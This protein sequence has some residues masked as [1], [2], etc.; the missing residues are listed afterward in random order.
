[1]FRFRFYTWCQIPKVLTSHLDPF[2]SA[3]HKSSP[4]P[5]LKKKIQKKK[6]FIQNNVLPHNHSHF[7]N[8]PSPITGS[9]NHCHQIIDRPSIYI[10]LQ[11]SSRL[12]HPHAST[13]SKKFQNLLHA[14]PQHQVLD[15]QQLGVDSQK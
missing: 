2:N 14:P 1:M 5:R 13:S 4:F 6:K 10:S 7:S 11:K 12:E 8:L 3:S 9:T 15:L